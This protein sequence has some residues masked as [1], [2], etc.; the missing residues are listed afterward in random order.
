MAFL[1]PG[2]GEAGGDGK[3]GKE[4]RV[5]PSVDDVLRE[6]GSVRPERDLVTAAAVERER[7][8]GSPCAG[9]EDGNATH[10]GVLAPKRASVPLN[11]RRMF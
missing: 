2:D 6:L 5:F 9:T 4:L 3:F 8:G 7:D 1:V 11:R 10:A